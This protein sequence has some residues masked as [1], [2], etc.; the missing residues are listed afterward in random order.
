MVEQRGTLFKRRVSYLSKNEMGEQ[1]YRGQ[2]S[3][4]TTT[5]ILSQWK[6][7]VQLTEPDEDLPPYLT[8]STLF[9]HNVLQNRWQLSEEILML[10][11]STHTTGDILTH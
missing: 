3:W 11:D 5:G 10:S 9:V 8:E 4:R 1:T 6:L 2:W 7:L